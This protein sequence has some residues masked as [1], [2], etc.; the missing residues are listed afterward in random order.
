MENEFYYV[1]CKGILG[2]KTNTC[3]FKWVYG[4]GAPKV[5]EEDFEKCIV[6][7]YVYIMPEKQLSKQ[8]FSD[9]RF[10]S[11]E[12]ENSKKTISYRRKFLNSFCI[13]YNIRII[14]NEVWAEVGENYYRFVK[15][16]I[17]NLHG[18]YY[19]LAD[20][21]NVMLLNNGFLTLYASA[22]CIKDSKRCVVTFAPPN[23]GKTLTATKLCELSECALVGEDIVISD[24]NK[25]YSCPW[26]NSYRKGSGRKA[27]SAG[28]LTRVRKHVQID[29]IEEGDLTDLIVLSLG[30]PRI[31]TNKDSAFKYVSVLNGYLFNYYSSPIV[32]ILGYFDEDYYKEWNEYSKE[33]LKTLVDI[34]N[35]HIIQSEESED[36]MDT[37]HKI[38]F[39]QII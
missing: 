38:I 33:L 34:S 11:Y 30:E 14:G 16:R 21:A 29:K 12:W 2:V 13:G 22:C 4:S 17:M 1:Y 7:F 24:G 37:I 8:G 15:N 27:D 5:C 35:C 20:L 25:V 10:Q 39:R 32:K 28:S 36:F 23:T 31:D 18:I 26:T 6:K 9:K 3:D 19:L